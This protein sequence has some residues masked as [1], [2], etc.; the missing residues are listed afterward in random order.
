MPIHDIENLDSFFQNL[1]KDDEGHIVLNMFD[2]SIL[3]N[4]FLASALRCSAPG[5]ESVPEKVRFVKNKNPWDGITYFTDKTLHLAP[6]VQ[7]TIKI[8]WLLEPG[9]LIPGMHN[10]ARSLQDHFDFILTYEQALLDYNPDK[11]K[12]FPC[13][14]SG[15]EKES[16]KMH[17][18]TKLVS[19]IYSEKKWL[20]GHRLRH[21]IADKLLPRI[22]YDKID[23]LGRG[24]DCPLEL[25]S[26]GTNDYM[27]QI[28]IE[29][30]K[31]PNYFADKIYDCFVTGT[32]P[33]YWGAPNIGDFFD[34]RGILVFST[35]Q[36]LI[37]ILKSLSREKYEAMLPYIKGNF[38][39]VKQYLTPDDLLFEETKK[40]LSCRHES[41]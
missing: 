33:I 20:T 34:I 4:S 3:H 30:L 29:N 11:F 25:K 19:M 12:F 7:S 35:P 26:E 1:Q 31:R 22:E 18:K 38:E 8:A 15:I 41:R 10:I 21:I 39:L 27:F 37:D 2:N 40:Y 6:Q 5:H 9:D 16:H 36:E 14:T 13:D 28:A 17:E 24:T 23:L 32:V